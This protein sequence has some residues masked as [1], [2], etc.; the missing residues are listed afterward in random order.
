MDY[1]ERNYALLREIEHSTRLSI[2]KKIEESNSTIVSSLGYYKSN[3][4]QK[5]LHLAIKV[6][7]NALGAI[8]WIAATE[9][10]IIRVIENKFPHLLNELPVV[11]G[12]LTRNGEEIGIITEDF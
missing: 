11:H 12:R 6:K 10:G 7:E 3:I 2:G 4:L 1:L 9:L 5:P 8:K